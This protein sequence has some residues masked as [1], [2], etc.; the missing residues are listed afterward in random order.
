MK[1]P[2]PLALLL[3]VFFLVHPAVHARETASFHPERLRCEYLVDPLG[4]DVAKPRL[5]WILTGAPDA[6]RGQMQSAYRLLVGVVA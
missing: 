1:S 3:A 5:D 6:P 2:G 4:I